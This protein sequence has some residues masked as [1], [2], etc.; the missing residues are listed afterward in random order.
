[1]TSR[2]TSSR[3]LL[4][5]LLVLALLAPLVPASAVGHAD[6]HAAAMGEMPCCDHERAN[7]QAPCCD[8][9]TCPDLAN[10]M[11]TCFAAQAGPIAQSFPIPVVTAAGVAL[12]RVAAPH[13]SDHPSAVFR[14]PIVILG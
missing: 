6:A 3:R 4:H 1:M 9:Q 2:P 5:A 8:G 7:S 11:A 13:F 12:A 10:C 14:P